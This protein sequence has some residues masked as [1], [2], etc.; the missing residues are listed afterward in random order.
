MWPPGVARQT[1]V[2]YDWRVRFAGSPWDARG[3]ESIMY[4]RACPLTTVKP[5]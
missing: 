2:G 3:P 4:V 1:R 5:R